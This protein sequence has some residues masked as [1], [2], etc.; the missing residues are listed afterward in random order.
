M[1]DQLQAMRLQVVERKGEIYQAEEK[2]I[3]HKL[4]PTLEG[5]YK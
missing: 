3:V 4:S 1:Q 2:E 5:Q